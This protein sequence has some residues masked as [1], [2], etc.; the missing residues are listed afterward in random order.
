MKSVFTELGLV[1]GVNKG[2]YRRGEW[3]G[4]GPVDDSYNPHTGEKIGQVATASLAQYN[5]CIAAM[6][7]ERVRWQTTPAPVRGEIVRQIG[8]SLRQKK[9]AL[10][11]LVTMEM[12]KIKSEGLGEVQE[13]IDIC[14]FA[15]GL[16]RSLEGKVIP[17]ERPGHFMIENWNPVGNVGVITAFNFPVAVMGWN[18]A[19]ALIAGDTVIWKGA[20]TTSLCTVATGKI[21]VDVLAKHGYK[22]IVTICCGDGVKVGAAMVADPRV[23]LVSFT[24]STAVGRQVSTVVHTRF[25]KTIL[26][27]GGNNATVVMPDADLELVF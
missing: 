12:G 26:E 24:G 21:I 17:S 19:L 8:D 10:G 27:L 14:D 22:S 11:A 2:V 15:T 6:D 23:A 13:F 5:E 4:D 7:E 18:A 20:Q 9:E 3:V 16:S 1:S 25:G